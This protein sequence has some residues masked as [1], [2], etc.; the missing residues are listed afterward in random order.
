MEASRRSDRLLNSQTRYCT[1][2]QDDSA[3]AETDGRKNTNICDR[4][5]TSQCDNKDHSKMTSAL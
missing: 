1:T 3:A 4:G 5:R 2:E